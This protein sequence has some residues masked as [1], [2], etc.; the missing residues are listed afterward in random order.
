MHY[1][2]HKNIR[3]ISTLV[4]LNKV[5]KKKSL[6][7]YIED[8]VFDDAY[9]KIFESSYDQ[10]FHPNRILETSNY[11]VVITKQGIQIFKHNV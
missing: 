8:K 2:F 5:N 10:V 11:I 4:V 7:H 1:P 6:H 9:A 3:D